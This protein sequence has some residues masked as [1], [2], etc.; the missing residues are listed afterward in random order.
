MSGGLA[1]TALALGG[2]YLAGSIPLAIAEL[3]RGSLFRRRFEESAWA[4][5]F[6]QQVP[7]YLVTDPLAGLEGAHIVA[8]TVVA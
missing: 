2:I 3:L 5:D 6:L 8:S 1:V 7:V 4:A